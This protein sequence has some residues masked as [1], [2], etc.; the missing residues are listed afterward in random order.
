LGGGG[1]I[2][3]FGVWLGCDL[4]NRLLL[5]LLLKGDRKENPSINTT[6]PHIP[7]FDKIFDNFLIF[8]D[9]LSNPII[10]FDLAKNI[11]SIML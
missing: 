1:I 7:Y 6:M 9:A 2:H 10:Y 5:L 11:Y 4:K 8:R 3:Q